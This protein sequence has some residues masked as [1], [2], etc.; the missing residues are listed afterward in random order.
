MLSQRKIGFLPI[1]MGP[2]MFKFC[3]EQRNDRCEGGQTRSNRNEEIKMKAKLAAPMIGVISA[4]L[5]T[6]SFA[7]QDNKSDSQRSDNQKETQQQ[8]ESSSKGQNTLTYG[9]NLIGQPVK[10]SEGQQIGKIEELMIDPKDGKIKYG[11]LNVGEGFL[12]IGN[13]LIAVPWNSLHLTASQQGY[14]LDMDKDALAKA[15]PVDQTSWQARRTAKADQG[16]GTSYR[17]TAGGSS[18]RSAET[19]E[20]EKQYSGTVESIDTQAGTIKVKKMMVSHTFK[21]ADNISRTSLN[22]FKEGDEIELFYTEKGSENVVHRIAPMGEKK[23]EKP[24]EKQ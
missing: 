5:V 6:G 23:S 1:V 15:P 16:G 21:L 4:C 9:S 17:Q 10:N 20:G 2:C 24:A 3:Y 7:A 8:K 12:G 19:I 18:D 14:L 11:V 22:Q 13:K